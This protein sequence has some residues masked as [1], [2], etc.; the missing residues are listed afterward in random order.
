MLDLKNLVHEAHRRSLWQVVSMDRA[1][2]GPGESCVAHANR[3]L[4]KRM[5]RDTVGARAAEELSDSGS[6]PGSIVFGAGLEAT[7]DLL[8]GRPEEARQHM[9]DAEEYLSGE[10]NAEF[11]MGAVLGQA[12]VDLLSGLP[13]VARARLSEALE[14]GQFDLVEADSRDWLPWIGTLFWA[15]D[16]ESARE[17]LAR[18]GDEVSPV[19]AVWASELQEWGA[20]ILAG[21]DDPS[22][23]VE[24]LIRLRNRGECEACYGVDVALFAD[25]AEDYE[26]AVDE[27]EN[28][29]WQADGGR[30]GRGAMPLALRR[31]G[32]LYEELGNKGKAIEWYDRLVTWYAD[33][34]PSQRPLAAEARGRVA[35][36]SVQGGS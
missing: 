36:L 17:L 12:V 8:A 6:G 10:P 32:P 31:L 13:E 3:I 16:L 20:A 1:V 21:A 19:Q 15:G 5:L 27:Y 14:S 34:E 25:A 2:S 29:F 9:A 23:G 30:L 35:A 24:R 7:G 26:R 33:A 4:V 22:T 28:L 18:A 11:L